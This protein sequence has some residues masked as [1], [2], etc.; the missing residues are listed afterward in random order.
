MRWIYPSH[1]S[2]RE[3]EIVSQTHIRYIG[4]IFEQA[5]AHHPVNPVDGFLEFLPSLS[6]QCIRA[7]SGIFVRTN[8]DGIII[9]RLLYMVLLGLLE[10]N[11]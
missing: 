3:K 7:L 11:L 6:S 8:A 4:G 10:V 2:A 9:S 5:T 1:T